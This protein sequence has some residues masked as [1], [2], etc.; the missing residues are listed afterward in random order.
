MSDESRGSEEPKPQIGGEFIIPVAALV[1]TIYYFST[2]LNSPWTAQVNAFMV[3]FVLFVV[4]AVFIVTRLGRVMA[5]K[6]SM[7]VADILAPRDILPK[8]AAFI[9]ICLLYVIGIE[10]LGYTL[11]TFAFLW[12]SMV[13]LND[14]RRKG[15]CTVLAA[16]M[17]VLGYVVFIAT[18]ETRLPRGIIEKAI[19]ALI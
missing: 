7:G 6:A 4:I 12:S 11:T 14:F 15:V 19:A 17:T 8:R 13:L 18:F 2:I 9:A 16:A 5:G 1:F 3:G 10:W